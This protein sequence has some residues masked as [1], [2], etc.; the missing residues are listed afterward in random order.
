MIF[1]LKLIYLFPW[2][3]TMFF[4]FFNKDKIQNKLNF[5]DNSLDH[6]LTKK[7]YLDHFILLNI[8]TIYINKEHF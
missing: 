8:K 5:L 7:N 2:E 6:E 4:I 1:N 3:I